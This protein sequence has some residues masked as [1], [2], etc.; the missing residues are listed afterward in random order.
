LTKDINEKD[1]LLEKNVK[2]EKPLDFKKEE[3]EILTKEIKECREIISSLES[4][5]VDL[6]DAIKI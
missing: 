1:E 2:L 3:L 5:N 4:Q 6:K